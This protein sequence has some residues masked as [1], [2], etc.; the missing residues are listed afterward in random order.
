M[1]LKKIFFVF[2]AVATISGVFLFLQKSSADIG[3][4]G[5]SSVKKVV[6]ARITPINFSPTNPY[7]GFATG[8]QRA[9]IAPEI[10]G[11]VQKL[12][13][14]EGEN[15]HAGEIVAIIN[16]STLDAQALG[17]SQVTN[18]FRKALTDT[19]KLYDQKIHEAE[20]ALKKSKASYS[21]GDATKEDVKLAEESVTSAKRARDLQVTAAQVQVSGARNQNSVAESYAQKQTIRAPFA[22]IITQRHTTVGSFISAGTPIYS[23]SAPGTSEIELSVPKQIIEKLFD[24]QTI[25]L[26]KENSISSASFIYAKNPFLNF[27]SPNGVIRLRTKN[28]SDKSISIG[29]YVCAGLPLGSPRETIMVPESSILHEFGD[30]FVFVAENNIAHKKS[31]ALGANATSQTEILTGLQAGETI[32]IQ[33]AHE[34]QN[35]TPITY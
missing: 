6:V 21:S 30:A 18:D 14:N 26:T 22:G 15:V 9:E 3:I 12:L 11:T 1:L 25:E 5:Q 13:K 16:D 20:A 33:G 7:C 28:P 2:I 29:D 10:N 35:N 23:L 17:S 32:I 24:N 8:A 19:K 27:G 31:V 34:I 4:V